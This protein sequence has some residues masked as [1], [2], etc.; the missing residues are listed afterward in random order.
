MLDFSWQVRSMSFWLHGG[1]G[2]GV[3]LPAMT[4]VLGPSDYDVSSP[5]SAAEQEEERALL[6]KALEALRR[7]DEHHKRV[8]SYIAPGMGTKQG[9]SDG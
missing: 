9:G 8:L 6:L 7:R 1:Y 2:L 4:P 5:L 3:G